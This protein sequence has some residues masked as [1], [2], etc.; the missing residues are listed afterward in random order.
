MTEI[1][2][3]AVAV[4]TVPERRECL[5]ET[6]RS[7]GDSDMEEGYDECGHAWHAF[8]G[9]RGTCT[10]CGLLHR[11]WADGEDAGL[12]ADQDMWDELDAKEQRE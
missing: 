12:S 3:F 11:V 7:W 4:Q 2:D 9:D 1:S 6:R 10:G 8:D 5:Q